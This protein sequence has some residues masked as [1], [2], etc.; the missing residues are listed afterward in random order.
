[1]RR[2]T[3][4]GLTMSEEE[5]EQCG[6]LIEWFDKY[7]N[8]K[9]LME[10]VENVGKLKVSEEKKEKKGKNESITEESKDKV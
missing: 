5:K 2:E 4:K 9:K 7:V 1:M 8:V 6:D 10:D 3:K